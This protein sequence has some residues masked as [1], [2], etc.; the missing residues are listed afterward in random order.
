MKTKLFIIL[1]VIFTNLNAQNKARWNDLF[2]YSN[3]KLLEEVN[4]VLYCG[5]ENG[6]YLYNPNNTTEEWI[7]LN[8]TNFL[9]N[10][11]V[12]AMAYD[13]KSDS[14]LIGYE[15][16]SLDLLHSGEATMV[17]DIKWKDFNG[18]KQIN[19]I[20]IQDGMAYVSGA[21]G[22]VSFDMNTKEFRETTRT[23]VAITNNAVVNDATIKDNILYIATTN[24][25]YSTELTSEKLNKPNINSWTLPT[26]E[27]NV[28][29]IELL[30]DEIYY[31]IGKELKSLNRILEGNNFK[32]ILDLKSSNNKLLITQDDQ[33]SILGGVTEEIS[34]VENDSDGN[35]QT[36][37]VN[38]NTAIYFGSKV[39]GGSTKYGLVDFSKNSEG[40]PNTFLP[41]GPY[42]NKSFSITSQNS[43]VWIAPGGMDSFNN[44]ISN[45]DGFSYFDSKSWNH[46]SSNSMNGAK[47]I[48]KVA[49]DP[50]DEN[51]F[52]A[53][54]YFELTQWGVKGEPIGIM[55][56]KNN[57]LKPTHIKSPLPVLYRFGGGSF[58]SQGNFYLSQGLFC[59]NCNNVQPNDYSGKILKG[60]INHIAVKSKAGGW[61]IAKRT[62]PNVSNALSPIIDNKYIYIPQARAGGVAVLRKDS[63]EVVGNIL[64]KGK[65]DMPTNNVWSAALDKTGTLWIGT[66]EGLAIT[67]GIENAADENN[68][69]SELIVIVQDG[70]P[71]ALLTNVGIYSIKVDNANRKWIATNGAGVYYLSENG[72]DTKLHFTEKNSPLPSNVVYDVSIDEST[73]KV[74]FAT[75]KGVVSYLG[76]VS[77]EATN[78]DQTIA[79][80]NPYRPEY[81]GNITIK[82]LPNRA[83]VKITDIVGN[84]LFE[85]KAEGGIVEWN[86]KNS[87]G[88]SVASGIYLVL[89]TNSDG[90]ET[91][92]LKIAIVR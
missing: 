35:L 10:V 49:V 24:G 78:F 92:T 45:S 54:P 44:V 74:Y 53:I 90:T 15:N 76:D 16:G 71:E 52:I 47:D 70:I 79:Y 75:E 68:L 1:A 72:E 4:G 11:G 55:E 28:T 22:L 69:K 30:D 67:P 63:Y 9:N 13:S 39:Y 19:H 41:Q 80:P 42:S 8:K 23:D 62:N 38:F 86:T 58:D 18:K 66:N 7:K 6:I 37:K 87:R 12:S 3:V 85:Q 51:H 48:I 5:T 36:L 65:Q 77:T 81:K 50:T 73:G 83:I 82:N 89:M 20:L 40:Q 56:F 88:K 57:S 27:Q 59:E 31:S 29:N 2:S 21:F 84:L 34:Y 91:K 60:E 17:L 33:V 26:F 25:I 46:F 14:F 32:N 43:K 64:S 61:K